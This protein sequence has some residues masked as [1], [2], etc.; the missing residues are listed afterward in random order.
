M[1][2]LNV[3][4]VVILSLI[5]AANIGMAQGIYIT[6]N[7]GYSLGAGTQILGANSSYTGTTH[8]VEVICGSLGEGFKFG[9]SAGYMFNQNLGTE[10]GLSYWPGKTF[11][12]ISEA[13]PTAFTELY[14]GSGFVAVPSI[15][16]SAGMTTINPY[17]R[18]GVV[19]GILNVKHELRDVGPAQT[20]V[21][22]ME[23]TGSLAFGYAGALGVVIPAGSAVDLFAEVGLHSVTYS[24]SHEELTGYTVNGVDRLATIT[25][26]V[27][28]YKDSYTS[29]AQNTTMAVRRPFSS[30]GIVVGARINL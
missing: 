18:F 12:S 19:L 10:L 25:E 21:Y 8:N 29:D 6:A 30:I 17:A 14:S 5:V 2:R 23:E 26:K 9:A 13:G 7:V 11:E 1:S 22:T 4:M 28:E 16:V 24:P 27:V 15:V 20:A 3:F